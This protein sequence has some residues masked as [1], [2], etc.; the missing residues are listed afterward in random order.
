MLKSGYIDPA[1]HD[2]STVADCCSEIERDADEGP[3]AVVCRAAYERSCN[4]DLERA[5]RLTESA[6][7]RWPKAASLRILLAE[8]YIGAAR[9]GDA[10]REAARGGL[11]EAFAQHARNQFDS[12]RVRQAPSKRSV[13]QGVIWTSTAAP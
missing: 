7:Q 6:V 5:I 10:C 13:C 8:Q 4:L 12:L 2:C 3:T 1:F 9:Y 11:D